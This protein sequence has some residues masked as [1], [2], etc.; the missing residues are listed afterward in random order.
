MCKIWPGFEDDQLTVKH[1]RDS[2]HMLVTR[3]PS[4]R[5]DFCHFVIFSTAH[6]R[7]HHSFLLLRRAS[8]PV[9]SACRRFLIFEVKL[10]ADDRRW[11]FTMMLFLSFL[12]VSRNFILFLWQ[13]KEKNGSFSS[14]T[15]YFYSGRGKREDYTGGKIRGTKTSFYLKAEYKN[16]KQTN[17][18]ERNTKFKSKSKEHEQEQRQTK[19]MTRQGVKE[20]QRLNTQTLMTRR[21]TGEEGGGRREE[22]RWGNERRSTW[23]HMKGT[24][25]TEGARGEQGDS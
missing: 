15:D 16:Q 13:Q 18:D 6:R 14:I 12:P 17:E 21:G 25:Q 22:A 11:S 5:G 2:L 9:C 23:E 10:F 3:H 7:W 8:S 20:T 24:I 19:T 1:F 4:S